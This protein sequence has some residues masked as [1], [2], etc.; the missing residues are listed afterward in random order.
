MSLH[1]VELGPVPPPEGG[2]SRQI[3]AIK[4]RLT[5]RGIKCTL[6]ATTR[7]DPEHR[8]A[9]NVYPES[10]LALVSYLRESDA[11]IFHLHLGGEITPRVLALAL[12]VAKT[13]KRSIL[14]M[15]SGGFPKA[16]ARSSI[17]RRKFTASILKKFDHLIGVSDDISDALRD[18]GIPRE[19]V[20]TIPPYALYLPDPD[21]QP[22]GELSAFLRGH[23]PILVVVGALETEYA[24]IEQIAAV[25][26]LAEEFANI[27]L[28]IAGDGSIREKVVESIASAGL[29]GS[30]YLA[31]NVSHDVSLHLLQRADVS[32]RTTLYDGDAIS[33]RESLFLGTPVLATR[34]GTRPVGAH[35]IDELTPTS[36][37]QGVRS[38]L[39]QPQSEKRKTGSDLSQIERVVDL[40][41]KVTGS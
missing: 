14:T 26:E 16:I 27:G 6:V 21:I 25:K 34:V 39:R 19:R 20:E 10:P 8:S 22:D 38:I 15:H 33:I 23:S 13:A 4:D 29:S 30:V 41:L 2:V 5:D 36:I 1:V 9:D 28:V 32:L 7:S 31:G 35:F 3:V 24:P 11:D 18:L 37:A 12:A 40:Y 17:F